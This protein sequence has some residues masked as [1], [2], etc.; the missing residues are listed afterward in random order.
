LHKNRPNLHFP[1]LFSGVIMQN[2][3]AE[4]HFQ[5]HEAAACEYMY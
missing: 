2:A 4:S 5:Q 1:L 3:P